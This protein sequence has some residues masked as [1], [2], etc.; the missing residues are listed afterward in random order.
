[1]KGVQSVHE[2]EIGQSLLRNMEKLT[3][4]NRLLSCCSDTK[5]KVLQIMEHGFDTRR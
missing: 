2:C 5:S 3:A 1:M 4:I